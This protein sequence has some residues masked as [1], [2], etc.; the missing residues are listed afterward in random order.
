MVTK[1][2]IAQSTQRRRKEQKEL[3]RI[4]FES[5]KEPTEQDLSDLIK[6]KYTKAQFDRERSRMF[7]FV[8]LSIALGLIY[9][10]FNWNFVKDQSII[11][12]KGVDAMTF[13]EIQDIPHTIQPPPPPPNLRQ[14]PKIIEVPDEEILEEVDIEID[15]ETT[16]EMSIVEVEYE[17]P[18]IE[19]EEAEEIFY[20]AETPPEPIGGLK[21]FYGYIRE[22]LRYPNKARAAHVKGRVFVQFVVDKDGKLTNLK[23]LKGIGYGCDKEALRVLA[24]A[25]K[26]KPGKQRGKPVKVYMSIPIYFELK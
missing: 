6:I 11:S 17:L 24:S 20:V 23:I 8:G 12:L 14:P 26:W 7:F 3:R 13:E 2:N 10:I 22:N 21:A 25:P 4:Q 1:Q 15:V 16:E 19:E 9:T 5:K 18:P